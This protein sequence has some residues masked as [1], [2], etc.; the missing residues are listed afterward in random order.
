MGLWNRDR[1]KGIKEPG[2]HRAEEHFRQSKSQGPEFRNLPGMFEDKLGCCLVDIRLKGVG[3]NWGVSSGTR[4]QEFRPEMNL[5][6][7]GDS[8]DADERSGSGCLVKAE[9]T[10]HP[11][12]TD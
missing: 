5:G 2:R 10:G 6:Q 9:L 11:D 12:G 4:T 3:K 1:T 8:G 7:V